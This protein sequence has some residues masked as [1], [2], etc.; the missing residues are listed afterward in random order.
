MLFST[1]FQRKAIATYKY[2]YSSPEFDLASLGKENPRNLK[3]LSRI[4]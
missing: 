2:K 3:L 1:S 4:K